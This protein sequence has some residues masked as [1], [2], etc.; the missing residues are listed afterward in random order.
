M[1]TKGKCD[2]VNSEYIVAN[3]KYYNLS[4]T[5]FLGYIKFYYEYKT[6]NKAYLNSNAY[7]ITTTDWYK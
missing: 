1:I 3:S 5:H 4:Y 2:T 6:H 7:Y